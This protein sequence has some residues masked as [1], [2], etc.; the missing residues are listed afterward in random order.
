MPGLPDTLRVMSRGWLSSNQ[1]VFTTEGC[2]AAVV[3]TGHVREAQATLALTAQA[4]A[5]RPL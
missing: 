3:D 2:D 5:G 4:L 1:V